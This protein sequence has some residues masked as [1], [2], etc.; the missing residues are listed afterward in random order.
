M[1]IKEA[2]KEASTTLDSPKE[3]RELMKSVLNCDDTELI[4][5]E[6]DE[7]FFKNTFYEKVMK[8]LKNT[9]LEYLTNK[10][11]FYSKDFFIEDGVLIPRPETEILVDKAIEIL[12]T[13][14]NPKVVEIGVG[15]G[16][17]SIMLLLRFPNLNIVAT[18][19]NENAIKLAKRNAKYHFVDD[20]I[21]FAKTSLLDGI[22]S[23]FDVIISNPPYIANDYP[24]EEQVL[25]EPRN[26][27]FGGNKGDEILKQIISLAKDKDT[28]YL[29][30]E[31]GYDQKESMRKALDGF[32]VKFYKDYA[33]HDRGFV[34]RRA[35]AK[36]DY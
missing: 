14:Q 3:A 22:K 7:L 9:P 19:I 6:N 23:K 33:G 25:K 35:H 28:K 26:A 1:K 18:D 5:Q 20:R 4:L 24:L 11:S 31:M 2:L 17:I 8:R 12:E 30:C 10:V 29:I 13:F 21:V 27:L 34:A 32:D 15:S 16:V 36:T